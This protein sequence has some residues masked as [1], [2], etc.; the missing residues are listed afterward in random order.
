MKGH[1]WIMLYLLAGAGVTAYGYTKSQ[2]LNPIL[3]VTW[4]LSVPSIFSGTFTG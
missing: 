1:H 4:P 3:I 2:K